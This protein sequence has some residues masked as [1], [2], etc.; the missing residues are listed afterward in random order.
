MAISGALK[1][2]VGWYEATLPSK[3]RRSRGHF[4]TP[5][6]LVEHIFD[7]CGY[8]A[9]HD[10]T[11]I[12]VLD[13]ACGSGNFLAGVAHRLVSFGTRTNLSQE[14]L[15]TL[16]SRN[17]WGFDPD[18]VSC[19][20]AEMQLRAIHC[21]P[22]DLH[23]HQADGL[24]LPWDGEPCVD[25]FLANPPY[26]AAKNTDLSGYRSAQ[27][28]GQADSYLLFLN[29]GLQ[30]VRPRG[31]LGLVLPD[32]LLAR[33]NAAKERAHLLKEF[34]IHHLWHLADVVAAHVGAIVI[35]AQKCPPQSTHH[36]S[37]ARE[38]WQ[39]DLAGA[40]LV[41]ANLA[42]TRGTLSGGQVT[43]TCSGTPCGNP[44]WGTGNQVIPQSLF[45]NQPGSEFRYLLSTEPGP[46]IER[47]RS[48]FDQTPASHRQLAPLSEFLSI[49]RGEELGMGSPLLIHEDMAPPHRAPTMDD[50]G[51]S[52]HSYHGRGTPCGQYRSNKDG[53]P[54]WP[55]PNAAP[56][57]PLRY[58]EQRGSEYSRGERGEDVEGGP[59]WSPV[60]CLHPS[61]GGCPASGD[62]D[63]QGQPA[64]SY[65]SKGTPCG[66]PV[67]GCPGGGEQ[68]SYPVLRGGRAVRP[69]GTSFS[70]WWISREAITKPIE[71]Y[72]S[73][74]LLVVKSTDRLQAALDPRG[75]VA[76]QTL[77]L[78]HPHTKETSQDDL[79]FFLSLLN[80][81]LL[82][83]YVYVLHTAYK[84]V[85]P[86]IEQHVLA[87]LPIPI[88]ASNEKHQIIE[89]AKLLARACSEIDPVVEW[90]EPVQN[91]YE[92]QER[93]ICA[94]YASALC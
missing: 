43:T 41:P 50:Q 68:V 53:R 42:P 34:T 87:R 9:A 10:L 37:W 91:L 35:I 1:E 65:H 82:R 57:P 2:Q 4:S 52:V 69:Y 51:S 48:Y 45:L 79:Y 32:P 39:K 49:R 44:V 31:W 58:T 23:I 26:L 60:R 67:D 74:K 7:A 33:T 85:Q 81:C 86:Q 47:L 90:D 19:F 8:T 16:I 92:E 27:Q 88:I 28:R 71:R 21:L 38:K 20:L 72:L 94:L 5:P 70:G 55:P 73:P 59:L 29:L 54:Q 89:R 66:C 15:A 93:A 46:A 11:Q 84:W 17:V 24:A 76:L 80:S 22:T 78:L 77:Y 14:E 62:M 36:I 30:I 25:L 6:R 13:P 12:R 64:H 56:P 75:H 83:Q 3:E 63:D 40:N 18:P 61:A